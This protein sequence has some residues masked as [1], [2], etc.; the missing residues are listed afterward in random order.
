MTAMKDGDPNPLELKTQYG[1]IQKQLK[2]K[3]A[4]STMS[5][6]YCLKK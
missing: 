4:T 3:N 1:P 5:Y 2:L 6:N